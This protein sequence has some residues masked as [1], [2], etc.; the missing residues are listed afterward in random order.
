[1]YSKYANEYLKD[2]V[3]KFLN[4]PNIKSIRDELALLRAL[5]QNA[6]DKVENEETLQE[7]SGTVQLLS[8]KVVSCA[9]T[10]VRIEDGMNLNLNV[11]ELQAVANQIVAIIKQEIQDPKVQEKLAKR[12]SELTFKPQK[13]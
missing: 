4:D 13:Q 7:H 6:L 12:I 11:I 3:E 8:E 1:L 2:K 5:L 9:A 10:L